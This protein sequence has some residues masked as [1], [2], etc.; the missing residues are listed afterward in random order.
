MKLKQK[1]VYGMLSATQYAD[2]NGYNSDLR[3]PVRYF[4]PAGT[5]GN[6]CWSRAIHATSR[7][8]ADTKED[9]V[10]AYNEEIRKEIKEL[11]AQIDALKK[12]LI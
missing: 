1:P 4:I 12:E 5:N 9:A 6:L 11:Q 2:D 10:A 8:Y 7:R 3:R